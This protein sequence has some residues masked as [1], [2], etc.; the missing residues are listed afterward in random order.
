VSG[1]LLVRRLAPWHE[2][3][4]G[5]GGLAA[6]GADHVAVGVVRNLYELWRRRLPPHPPSTRSST[7]R[8]RLI[9]LILDGT[10]IPIDRIAADRPYYSGK[11]KCHGVDI[12]VLTDP[13]GRLLWAS[14]AL[15]GAV[16][17]PAGLSMAAPTF[18]TVRSRR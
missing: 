17:D 16:H 5:F 11:H 12:Q 1:R 7:A 6:D 13:R 18:P 8:S 2:R 3:G 15:P 14:A 9:Y 10:L 4:G